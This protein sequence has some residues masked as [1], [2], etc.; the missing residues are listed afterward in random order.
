MMI[1]DERN[2]IG[3]FGA[4]TGGSDLEKQQKRRE[5]KIYIKKQVRINNYI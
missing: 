4:G 2:K 1:C 3:M 5:E